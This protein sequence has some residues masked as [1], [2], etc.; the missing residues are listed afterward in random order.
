MAEPG[1]AKKASPTSLP[2]PL[3]AAGN[4]AAARLIESGGFVASGLTGAARQ[5]VTPDGANGIRRK[6][7]LASVLLPKQKVPGQLEF[8]PGDL[9]SLIGTMRKVGK[10]L[11]EH[12]DIQQHL[13]TLLQG[14]HL[15]ADPDDLLRSLARIDMRPLFTEMGTAH[16]VAQQ[17]LGVP[18][19]FSDN[20]DVDG[21]IRFLSVDPHNYVCVSHSDKAVA[22]KLKSGAFVA[23]ADRV[24]V[25][26]TDSCANVGAVMLGIP[27]MVVALTSATDITGW[28]GGATVIVQTPQARGDMHDVRPALALRPGLKVIVTLERLT[29][30]MGD[31]KVILD[32]YGGFENRLA[33]TGLSNAEVK[34]V[35]PSKQY[36]WVTKA[37][38]MLWDETEADPARAR[39]A[40]VEQ[41]IGSSTQD[42]LD[43][44]ARDAAESGFK[45]GERYMI[46]NYRDSGHNPAKGREASHPELDTGTVGFAQLM[47]LVRGLG[48]VPV[49]MGGPPGMK[50]ADR[51]PHLVE[52][53][54][55]P[56][57]KLTTGHHRSKRQAEYGLLAYLAS[58]FSIKG[59]AMRSGGT[60]AMTYAGIETISLD[61]SA[62]TAASPDLAA[63]GMAKLQTGPL[64]SWRRAAMRE[65]IMPG[66]FH[67]AFLAA[68]RPDKRDTDPA[69]AGKLSEADLDAVRQSIFFFFGTQDVAAKRT[70]QPLPGSPM[71]DPEAYAKRLEASDAVGFL[72]FAK[73]LGS[74]RAKEEKLL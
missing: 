73:E 4:G 18:H 50:M 38:E 49:P 43:A 62:E 6:L 31:A 52:Y 11:P 53:W 28:V 36:E 14:D 21:L 48:Y 9:G 58:Q 12:P 25:P 61:L 46:V 20:A 17:L 69:W 7:V 70:V 22:S 5:F 65:L 74:R 35:V 60:D 72:K 51:G 54:L 42:D 59:L 44:Y 67:Q 30:G 66:I 45:R 37:T 40:I 26:G 8:G 33:I 57:A 32:Y 23:H 64:R 63:A 68:P 16:R 47:D 56:S 3:T 27:R 10:P 41:T 1:G 13:L 55:W 71:F 39:T 24:L 29:N 2:V 15:F 34:S 19:M